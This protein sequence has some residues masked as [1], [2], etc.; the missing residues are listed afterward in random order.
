MEDSIP[1]QDV[2]CSTESPDCGLLQDNM[3]LMWGKFKDLV[4][5]LK[6]EMDKNLFE[7]IILKEDLNQQLEFLLNS[8]ARFIMDPDEVTAS[9]NSDREEMAKRDEQR[10]TFEHEDEV[11]IPHCKNRIGWIFFRTIAPTSPSACGTKKGIIE[12]RAPSAKLILYY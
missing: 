3:S 12:L 9:L 10:K 7:F 2:E 5:E 8:K 1:G 11:Y 4:Y 6:R